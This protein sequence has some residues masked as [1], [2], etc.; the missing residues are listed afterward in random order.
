ME[1]GRESAGEKG[2]REMVRPR[3]RVEVRNGGGRERKA[4]C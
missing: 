1:E 2:G 3:K 4:C